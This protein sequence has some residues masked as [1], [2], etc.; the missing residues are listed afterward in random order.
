MA[1][2]EQ[3]YERDYTD[4][5]LRERLKGEMKQTVEQKLEKVACD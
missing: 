5:E 3:D 1:K 4:P 2:G